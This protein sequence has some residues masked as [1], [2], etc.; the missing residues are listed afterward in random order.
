MG[1]GYPNVGVLLAFVGAVAANTIGYIMPALCYM[2]ICRT[3]KWYGWSI[4]T[5]IF[6]IVCMVLGVTGEIGLLVTGG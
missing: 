1:V 3:G 2:K 4:F 5:L 6:G